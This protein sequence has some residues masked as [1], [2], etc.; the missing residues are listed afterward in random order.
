MPSRSHSWVKDAYSALKFCCLIQYP[1]ITVPLIAHQAN[2]N[3]LQTHQKTLKKE[4]LLYNL[5]KWT[6]KS[7]STSKGGVRLK[8]LPKF[9][10][11]IYMLE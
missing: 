2:A 11:L 7:M 9:K 1:I 6:V 8:Y 10:E 5:P 3:T 4:D